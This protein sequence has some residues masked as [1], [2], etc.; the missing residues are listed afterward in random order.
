MSLESDLH[1]FLETDGTIAAQLSG[2]VYANIAPP[3]AARPYAVVDMVAGS[4]EYHAGGEAGISTAEAEIDIF[5]DTYG[6]CLTAKEAVRQRI[7]GKRG[8]M[9]STSIRSIMLTE[10]RDLDQVVEF[11]AALTACARRLGITIA[12]NQTVSTPNA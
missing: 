1:S 7:S 12:Y 11:G 5:A 8:T 3:G 4:P 6:E 2:R 10:D 9:G